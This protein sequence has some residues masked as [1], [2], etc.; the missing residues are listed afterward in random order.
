MRPHD[1]SDAA[2]ATDPCAFAL[3]LEDHGEAV[4][5]V[6]DGGQC[7]TFRQ[8]AERAD[9]FARELTGARHLVA[10][11]T[12]NAVEPLV[13]YLGALRG[14]HVVLLTAPGGNER[15]YDTF[16]PSAVYTAT[17]GAWRLQRHGEPPTLHPDLALLLST[18]GTTGATKLV[19]LSGRALQANAASI[20]EYLQIAADDRAI[21]SLPFH[22]SYGMSVVN[23]HL[24]AGG[25][26]LLTDRSV[27]DPGF[28]AFF[29][30]EGATSLAGVPHTYEL[31]ERMHFRDR[32]SPRLRALTQA[33]GRLGADL[34][35]TYARWALA[36][37]AR[38]F[39]MYGQT[40][41]S[42][43]M[44]YL[45]PEQAGEHPDC[46]GAPIPGGEF[47]LL[48]DAGGEI[49]GPGAVG[50]LEYVGPNVMMGYATAIAH[51]AHGPELESLSTGDLAVR[52]ENGLY[53][54]VGRKSRFAKVF[55]LRIGLDEVEMR[56]GELGVRAAAVSDDSA[57]YL[58]VGSSRG[59]GEAIGRLA[60]EYKV[61]ETVFQVQ[62][63]DDLPTL[64]SGKI[65]YQAILRRAHESHPSDE[66]GGSAAAVEPIQMAFGRAFPRATVTPEDS[67]V[68]LG[69]DSLNY[70]TLSLAVEGALGHLPEHWEELT[71][72]EL[73]ALVP[74]R[75]ASRW[76]S[77]R[78]M[79][80]E[81]VLR[82]LA[83]LGV[84]VTHASTWV[85]S[86]GAEV[87]MI[88]AGYNLARYQKDRLGSGRGFEFVWSFF[89][90]IMLP[91]YGLLLVY[92]A[93][94]RQ[95][96]VPSLF[97]VSNFTGRFGS[98]MEPYWFLEAIIQCFVIFAAV[99]LIP[100]VRRALLANP[101]RF[102]LAFLAAAILLRVGAY[103]A[104]QHGHLENRTPDSNFYL[105]ALGWCVH[106]ATT[107]RR[108]YL[109][110]AFM[111]VL[112]ALDCL[113]AG[114]LWADYPWPAGISHAV[115]LGA[116]ALGLLW[117][118]R[119]PIPALLHA[120]VAAV[121][122]ASFYIYLTHVAP[123][124]VIY[125]KLGI[126]SVLLNLAVAVAVGVAVWWGVDR[127]SQL[128]AGRQRVS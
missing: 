100:P 55:G 101:W 128:R 38:F 57:I 108:R 1:I 9:A 39:V 50:E 98:A 64:A 90:R 36:R 8:L 25:R 76:W 110:T 71:V 61:P 87:L 34:V 29:D 69:G 123:V 79:E 37:N 117:V 102:G 120:G 104:F 82:A 59:V 19:R 54:V 116:A 125:W 42:P 15:L 3:R 126:K 75:R 18:S 10:I 62:P 107:P 114:G 11:E 41:A 122:A 119:T 105:L 52:L 5:V 7:L 26:L 58:A 89:Q 109:V 20:V 73:T 88:L 96:D 72:G 84:V 40:E 12:T 68:S 6:T 48:D 16:G 53:K 65:D 60:S 45:P 118:R 17:D 115:W 95:F 44:A 56:L 47:R 127:L 63:W 77:L 113:G 2:R 30:A 86:G 94:K 4:A 92:F 13:A 78:T 46:I 35:A 83:I 99:T 24:L 32:P 27:T 121:A 103:Q 111:I 21:T 31:L 22:Y 93:V 80:S 85:V 33:G 67:F 112:I 28:W 66:S 106:E 97:L 23:S 74:G 91:Y 81:V 14:G 43:R 70:V 51:L 124:W 49:C